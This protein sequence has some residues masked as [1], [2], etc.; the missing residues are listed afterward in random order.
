MNGPVALVKAACMLLGLCAF[1][2]LAA[3]G[4]AQGPEGLTPK[5]AQEIAIDAYI[6]GY[7]LVTSEVI[8]VK[9]SNCTKG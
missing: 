4:E 5:Q 2:V 6:Y 9:M 3:P 8:R 7:S 1:L